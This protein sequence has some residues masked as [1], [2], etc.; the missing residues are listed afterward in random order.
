MFLFALFLKKISAYKLIL[1]AAVFY[2]ARSLMIFTA[3]DTLGIYLSLILHMFSFA[4]I[5][6]ASVYWTDEIMDEEDKYEG[7]AFIGSTLTI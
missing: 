5:I 7:Q 1:I 6:P 2:V 3:H 4:I